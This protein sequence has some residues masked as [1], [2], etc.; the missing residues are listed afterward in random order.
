[1]T[2]W[3]MDLDKDGRVSYSD[4]QGTVATEPL[5]MEAFGQCLPH[6][7]EGFEFIRKILDNMPRNRIYCVN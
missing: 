7:K 1:M 3:K 5:L 6:N 2:L 4:F